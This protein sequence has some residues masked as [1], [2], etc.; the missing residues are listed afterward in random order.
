[1]GVDFVA[2]GNRVGRSCTIDKIETLR[3]ADFFR[4]MPDDLLKKIA[5]FAA[6][7]HLQ[8]GQVLFSQHDRA[9]ALYVVISGELRSVRQNAGG[10]EQV[11]STERAGALIGAVPVLTDGRFFSTVI[12]DTRAGV[13]GIEK[14]HFCALCSEYGELLWSLARD[15][16]LK[17]RGYAGL[18]ETLALHNVEQ[19]VA[20]YLL[21]LAQQRGIHLRDGCTFELT[22]S[23]GET[24]S[25]LGST[26]EVVSRALAALNRSGLIHLEGRRLVL[27]PNV[28]ALKKF[29]GIDN[30]MPEVRLISGNRETRFDVP[31][32]LI[33]VVLTSRPPVRLRSNQSRS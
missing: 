25:R 28:R 33:S 13:L 5:R 11:L 30:E 2:L 8:R 16:A 7:R 10:R 9:S 17:L 1:M 15:L 14:Q 27:V 31:G 19:R 18:I 6:I 29:V 26:R 12:A 22:L 32:D 20:K 21:D 24:A 4:S 23:R 3:Q